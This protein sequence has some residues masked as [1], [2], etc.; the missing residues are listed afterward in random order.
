MYIR[1]DI[2][3]LK[4]IGVKLSKDDESKMKKRGNMLGENIKPKYESFASA[5]RRVNS[6]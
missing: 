3:G 6:V 1:G 5:Y 4:G 2:Q